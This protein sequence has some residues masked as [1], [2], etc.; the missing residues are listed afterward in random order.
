[1]PLFVKLLALTGLMFFAP[2][3]YASTP[4]TGLQI[5]QESFKRHE[6]FPHVLEQQ[7]MILTDARGNSNVRKLSRYSRIEQDGTVKF[8]LLFKAPEALR[9]VALLAIRSA[10]GQEKSTVYLPAFGKEM[11]STG[12][13]KRNSRFLDTDFT[14][15]DLLPEKLSK[16]IYKR[17]A[18]Q[19]VDKV[20]Y[21]IIDASPG[22]SAIESATGYSKR[23]HFI[24][25]DNFFIFQTRYMD[26]HGVWVKRR[27][28]HDLKQVHGNRWRA[29]MILMENYKLKHQTLIK[30]NRR[31][32]SSDDVPAKVFTPAW[33]MNGRP[34]HNKMD[35]VQP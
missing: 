3:C 4:L 24:R 14:V 23:R 27:S 35:A 16:F 21:Y 29:N 13:E 15:D 33:L 9:K 34:D 19:A 31:F 1:M 18:D 17:R 26:Q 8:L 20:Q 25:Q 7:S 5:M 22:N 30:V 10:S 32:F 6:L 2:L 28:H 12:T 11:K